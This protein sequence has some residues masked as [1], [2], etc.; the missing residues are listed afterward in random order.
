MLADGLAGWCRDGD[1]AVGLSGDGIAAFFEPVVGSPDSL[2]S[3]CF[4]MGGSEVPAREFRAPGE[5]SRLV[6]GANG[7]LRGG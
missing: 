3:S 2:R 6:S 7:A 5:K 4:V 1:G